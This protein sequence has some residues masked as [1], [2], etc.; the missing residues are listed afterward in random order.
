MLLLDN[1]LHDYIKIGY[2]EWLN[3]AQDL[4]RAE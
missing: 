3:G 4:L 1:V 2:S